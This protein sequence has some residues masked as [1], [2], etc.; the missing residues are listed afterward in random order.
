MKK[1]IVRTM[2]LIIALALTLG[3]FTSGQAKSSTS[4]S[5]LTFVAEADSRVPEAKPDLNF[6]RDTVLYMDG[7]ATDPDIESYIQFTV[8]G[9]SGAVSGAQLRVYVT[10]ATRNGPALYTTSNTWTETAITWNNR[11][12]RTSSALEDKGALAVSSWVDYNV[13]NVITGNGTYSFILATDAADLLGLSSREGSAAPQ[14]VVTLAD[15]PTAPSTA[16]P[17]PTTIQPTAT[18]VAPTSTPT[19]MLPS[20]TA[21]LPTATSTTILPTATA[22]QSTPIS[23]TVSVQPT[24]TTA[25]PDTSPVNTSTSGSMWISS[26]E[27]MSLPTSGTAWDKMR[28]AAYGSW[29]AADLKNQDNKHDISTLAGALVFARTGDPSLRSKVRDAIMAA[30]RSLDETSEWQ[31]TNGVLAAGRQLGTYVIS[32]DLI[33][34]KNYDSVTDTEFRIWLTTIRTTNIGTHG[35]WKAITYTCENAAGNWN[36]FACASRIAA[37]IY[38]GDVAD[39]DRASAIIRAFFGERAYYPANAPGRYSYFEHTA[40]YQASWACADTTWTGIDPTCTKSGINIDGV[41]VEDASRGGGC[42]VL[43]GDG[44]MYSW[45]ALQGLF[46]ST[47]LLYRTGRYGNPYGWSNQALKRALDFMQRSGWGISNVAKYV[48]WIANAR[49]GTSFA[50]AANTTGRIMSWGDWLYRR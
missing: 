5:V 22:I 48:P 34:L 49:Y 39:V 17:T 7:G 26:T 50:T 29:G 19:T 36:T 47:E 27:L 2:S 43:Q 1:T 13:T 37:S 42:C 4:T 46:V 14:L 40:G 20:P 3:T 44:I 18:M 38:L 45:E 28:T 23:T 33:D 12:A 35:R 11:P 30:K 41:L 15:T 10:D 31:T 9:I 32:A 25:S 16:S 24:A 8:T 21:I 6:G